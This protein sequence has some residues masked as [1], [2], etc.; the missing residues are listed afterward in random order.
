MEREFGNQAVTPC[1]RLRNDRSATRQ[2]Q[3]HNQIRLHEVLRRGRVSLSNLEFDL[4]HCVWKAC[5]LVLWNGHRGVSVPPISIHHTLHSNIDP[6]EKSYWIWFFH[7]ETIFFTIDWTNGLSENQS[8]LSIYRSEQHINGSILILWYDSS[9]SDN[10][11][12]KVENIDKHRK[13]V[14][15]L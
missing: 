1:S 9:K 3:I 5:N 7:N 15:T 13:I 8:Q 14:G 12:R 4:Q 10:V 11:V 2:W 6:E